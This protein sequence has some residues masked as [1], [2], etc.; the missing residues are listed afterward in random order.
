VT[1]QS[2]AVPLCSQPS[3]PHP[4]PDK[5]TL[6]WHRQAPA[7]PADLP[8]FALSLHPAFLRLL[9]QGHASPMATPPPAFA[10]ASRLLRSTMAA[11]HDRSLLS[12][13]QYHPRFGQRL[14]V[15][16]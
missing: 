14:T 9:Q 4:L 11:R 3:W 10:M 6:P 16:K 15:E 7:Q 13:V 12:P 2:R 8:S 1:P 5:F